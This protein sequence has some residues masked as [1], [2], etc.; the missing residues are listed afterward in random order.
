MPV[1]AYP[2]QTPINSTY[3]GLR[4]TKGVCGVSILRAGAS[5]EQALRQTWMLVH[6]SMLSV[7]DVKLETHTDSIQ[8]SIE[9]W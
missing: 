9:L 6:P 7:G 5:M 4:F 2:I 8:G 1:E 3:E